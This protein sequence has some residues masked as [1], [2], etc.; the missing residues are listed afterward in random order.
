[1]YKIELSLKTM[2]IIFFNT[3]IHLKNASIHIHASNSL[4]KCHSY[5]NEKEN[6]WQIE[7][8]TKKLQLSYN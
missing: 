3:F 1:M 5:W 2:V 4:I 8:A 7:W 6:S